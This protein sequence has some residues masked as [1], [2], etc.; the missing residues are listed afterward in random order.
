MSDAKLSSIL[1]ASFSVWEGLGRVLDYG[2]TMTDFNYSLTEQ[3]ADRI[4][5]RAD[6]RAV[7]NDVAYVITEQLKLDLG[8]AG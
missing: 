5:I 7:G 2:D 6:W 1:Y 4:A 3:Q 8:V